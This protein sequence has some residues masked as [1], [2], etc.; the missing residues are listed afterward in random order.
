M[1]HGTTPDGTRIS[2]RRAGVDDAEAIAALTQAAYA[3]HVARIGREPQPMTA[4]YGTLA[5][6]HPIWLLCLDGEPAGVLV[7]MLE[8]EAVLIYSVAIRPERQ[9]LGLGRRL[10][11]F[12]E[13]QA[14]EQGYRS[15]RLYT[16]ERMEENIALYSRLGYEETGREARS[17]SALIH[18][19]KRLAET[20]R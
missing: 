18:M 2:I 16:N 11:A 7:L 14:K 8:A 20:P 10:L 9:R 3:K 5:A 19:A 1:T 4:D 12:A 6:E 13:Q 17:G 15:I